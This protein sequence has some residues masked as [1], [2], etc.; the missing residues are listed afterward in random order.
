MTIFDE[1]GSGVGVYGDIGSINDGNWHHLV[2]VID[3][4]V[5][6]ITYRDG[7]RAHPNVQQ[8]FS[9][10]AAGDIDT[11][12]PTNIGQDPTGQYP[13]PG[14]ADLDDLGVWHKALT[15]LEAASI[16]MAGVSNQLSFVGA[17]I[18]LTIQ[19]SGNQ[20]L[21]SWPAGTLQSADTVSG[22]YTDLIPVSPLAVSPTATNKFYRVRL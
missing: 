7:L 13:E 14:S 21:L 6:A 10:A 9:A 18:T 1:V 5:G 3:R 20:T 11:G 17:P 15:P 8:G 22:P 2:H 16:Y 12:A 19:R 4:A